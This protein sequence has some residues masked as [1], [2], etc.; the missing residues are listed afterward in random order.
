MRTVTLTTKEV[1][2]YQEIIDFH[3]SQKLSI[4]SSAKEYVQ[5]ARLFL[6]TISKSKVKQEILKK[7]EFFWEENKGQFSR[8]MTSEEIF[9]FNLSLPRFLAILGKLSRGEEY[10]FENIPG[11]ERQAS[12]PVEA[13]EFKGMNKRIKIKPLDYF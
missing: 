8:D 4:R 2:L 12:P 1:G 13:Y 6:K 10:E 7:D 11:W 9:D 5:I 3:Q